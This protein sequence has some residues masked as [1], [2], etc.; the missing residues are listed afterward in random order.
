MSRFNPARMSIK[1]RS[2]SN[3]VENDLSSLNENEA[4][5]T[6]TYDETNGSHIT[7]PVIKNLTGVELTNSPFVRRNSSRFLGNGSYASRRSSKLYNNSTNDSSSSSANPQAVPAPTAGEIH[8]E[9]LPSFFDDDFAPTIE[10][11]VNNHRNSIA[12][13][14][15]NEFFN[16]ATTSEKTETSSI[17]IDEIFAKNPR[18]YSVGQVVAQTANPFLKETS[19]IL[20]S[21]KKSNAPIAPHVASTPVINSAKEE[22]TTGK[23]D[24][25]LNGNVEEEGEI[26][27]SYFDLF[28]KKEQETNGI[29]SKAEIVVENLTMEQTTPILPPLSVFNLNVPEASQLVMTNPFENDDQE[30]N[31]DEDQIDWVSSDDEDILNKVEKE[32]EVFNR[33]NVSF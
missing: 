3:R 18:K 31:D 4:T 28:K 22:E 32:H 15:E 21:N 9:P 30:Q 17:S 25:T 24:E 8:I 7:P 1:S 33:N 14:K 6:T 12:K 26:D 16:E 20:V 5:T 11:L 10:N 19:P 27:F 23:D 29:K 13:Q 2:S